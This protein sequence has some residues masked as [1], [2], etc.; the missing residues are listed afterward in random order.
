M[1]VGGTRYRNSEKISPP[2]VALRKDRQGT[3]RQ[4]AEQLH[5]SDKGIQRG[6][7]KNAPRYSLRVR[8]LCPL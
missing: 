2:L 8:D 1:S 5:I 6:A 3:Q 4:K 7:Q